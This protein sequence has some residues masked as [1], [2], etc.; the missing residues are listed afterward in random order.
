LAS[1][2][3]LA[4]L[5]VLPVF[6]LE[7][8]HQKKWKPKIDWGVLAPFS[9]LAGFLIYLGINYQVTGSPFTFLTVE[10]QHWFNRFDPLS[11]LGGAV[12]W[13]T[14]ATYPYN[15]T[16]GFFP[17]VFAV[18]GLVMILLAVWRRLR[19]S[20]VLFMFLSWGL[21]VSTSWWIS[22]PRYVMGMFP[23]FFLMGLLVKRKAVTVA[24]LA[25]SIALL[26]YFTVLFAIGWW[27]F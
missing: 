23:M 27:A 9:A 21:A 19:P 18:L 8:F 13:T 7:Y 25:V 3:R 14:Q 15:L 10:S 5:I 16:S 24:I 22:V 17:V 11:G 26:L 12:S 20:Y 6:L 4:G 1:L 2:T